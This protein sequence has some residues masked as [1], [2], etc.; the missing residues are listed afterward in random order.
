MLDVIEKVKIFNRDLKCISDDG[1]WVGGSS[2]TIKNMQTGIEIQTSCPVNSMK[3]FNNKVLF[4]LAD[5]RLGLLDER[6]AVEY[7]NLHDKNICTIDCYEN[8]ILCGSWDHLAVLLIPTEN[9]KSDVCLGGNFYIKQ[10]FQHPQTVW[11]AIFINK[12][13]FATG[14]ADNAIRIFKDNVLFKE[15]HCHANVVRSLCFSDSIIY[16]IDNYGKLLKITMQGEILKS[17]NLDEMCFDICLYQ[18]IMLICGDNGRVFAVDKTLQ[19]LFSKKLPCPTCWSIRVVKN[20]ISIAGSDGTMYFLTVNE[21]EIVEEDSTD[22]DNQSNQLQKTNSSH[23]NEGVFVSEGV[24]YKVENSKIYKEL[25]SRWVLVGDAQG[26]YDHSFDVELG[27]KKYV[28]SFNDNENVHEVAS[29]FIH[30]NKINPTHHQEIVDYINKNYK[31][32]TLFKKYDAINIEGISKLL[33]DHPIVSTIREIAGGAK[34]SILKCRKKNVYHVEDLLFNFTSIPL[35]VIL[36]ICKYLY[37]K[38]I[39]IDLSFLFNYEFQNKKEAKAFVFLMTNMVEDPPF[40]LSKLNAK[41]KRLRDL[42]YL[43]LDDVLK[44]NDNCQIKNQYGENKN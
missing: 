4:G 1:V 13:T 6:N 21:D 9:D 30:E 31:R 15:M 39:W 20:R 28:L 33:P 43:T 42:G 38:E 2:K 22:T 23:T 11:K 32:S 5:G 37:C 14:C 41:V 35:F 25:G 24:K 27:D 10:V 17:R 44:Y 16:S 18:D 36:D 8:F 3:S 7:V 12:N 19:V 29:R 26:S 34:Y 40:D